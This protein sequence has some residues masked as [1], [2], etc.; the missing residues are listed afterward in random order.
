MG[1]ESKVYALKCVNKQMVLQ[2]K[3]Q[4]ALVHERDINA[5]CYHPCLMQF[6]KT[7]QD[8]ENVYFLTEFLGGGDL[9][10]AIREIEC[11]TK[12]Q[13]Q[14]Y[15]GCVVL[16]LG[17]LHGLGIMH[18]DVKPE[19]VLLDFDGNAKLVDFGC[20]KKA[21][22]TS[23]LVGTPE[24]LAPEVILGRG[25]TCARDWW[26]VGVMMHEFI[27]GPLPFGADNE[28]QLELFRDILESPL[29]LPRSLA[30]ETAISIISGLLER[31]PAL[32]LGS[33]LRGAK[34]LQEHRYFYRFDWRALTGHY[35][36]PP[37][38]PQADKLKS[39]WDLKQGE[40]LAAEGSPPF[41]P[42]KMEPGMQWAAAF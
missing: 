14:F 4:R 18:R 12:E 9:F 30:D 28:D 34:E 33:S 15:G 41:D 17:Y 27:V 2:E 31:T 3:Q 6:I 5:Q 24:Y 21:M 40:P 26:A 7:F 16:A 1:E 19:N 29:Q 10:Y 39:T 22:R 36:V 42:S 20:C 23:S 35:M 25:Y 32:R 11:L 37:W 8:A 38:K 13:A